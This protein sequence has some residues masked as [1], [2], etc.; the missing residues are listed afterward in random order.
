MTT[1]GRATA[2]R[3]RQPRIMDGGMVINPRRQVLR[4]H[5]LR[6]TRTLT[7]SSLPRGA[8]SPDAPKP[9]AT[10]HEATRRS[11]CHGLDPPERATSSH[12]RVGMTLPRARIRHSPAEGSVRCS[13]T[14]MRP[15]HNRAMPGYSM[16][17]GAGQQGYWRS[18]G[19]LTLRI[20][21][22]YGCG[23]PQGLRTV[24]HQHFCWSTPLWSPPPKSN[25]RPHPYHGSAAKRRAKSCC[26]R[27]RDS[28]SG[29]V[30][31][32]AGGR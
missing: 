10:V 25:R 27:L 17:K 12:D 20:P 22:H 29:A 7:R 32:S 31:C 2:G 18:D 14:A 13:V 1:A 26:C 6:S 30:M 21:F 11:T 28:G 3:H 19:A 8:Y 9:R 4:R 23:W 5:W 24:T 15:A 16:T